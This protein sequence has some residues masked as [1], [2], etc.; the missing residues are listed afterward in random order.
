MQI[1][2]LP[3]TK[4]VVTPDDFKNMFGVDLAH[5]LRSSDNES[6]YPVIFL[7]LVQNFLMD[8]CDERGFRRVKFENLTDTQLEYFQRAVLYQAYYAWKNGSI[9]LG[10]ESGYDAE[11]LVVMAQSDIERAEVPSRV[12]TMLHKAG[13]F[14]LKMRNRPRVT[15]GYPGIGGIYTGED[16]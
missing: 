10:L 7:S 9:A 8:W 16:F 13:L 6:N 14:N 4:L 15:R 2:P 1:K 12:V 3:V 11:K 5:I